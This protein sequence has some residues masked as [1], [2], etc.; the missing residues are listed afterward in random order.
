MIDKQII[1]EKAIENK[2]IIEF[3]Y[4]GLS[5]ICEPKEIINGQLLVLQTGGNTSKGPIDK[6]AIKKFVIEK[7]EEL[8][9][10]ANEEDELFDRKI[11]D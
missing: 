8:Q 5:R 10:I 3:K 9:V 7:I 1:L 6:A 4:S 2:N 11:V